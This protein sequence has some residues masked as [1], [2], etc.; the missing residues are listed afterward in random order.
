MLRK[1]QSKL[2]AIFNGMHL[3]G[4]LGRSGQIGNLQWDGNQEWEF[5]KPCYSTEYLGEWKEELLSDERKNLLTE[6]LKVCPEFNS[7]GELNEDIHYLVQ[8]LRIPFTTTFSELEIAKLGY[9]S[10]QHIASLE[11]TQIPDYILAKASRLDLQS[12]SSYL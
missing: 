7:Y 8:C 2:K 6:L 1:Q 4:Y 11:Y 9:N 5:K 10:G 12:A 3:F